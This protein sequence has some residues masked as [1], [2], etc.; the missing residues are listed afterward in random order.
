MQT[1]AT[2]FRSR[3]SAAFP[4]RSLRARLASGAS[5]S[6]FQAVATH[7]L[8][9][10]STI[11]IARLL[12][13]TGFGELAAVESSIAMFGVL[14]GLGLGLTANKHL[15][16]Y[17]V[18]DPQRA[19]RILGLAYMTA[20][21]SGLFMT[22]LVV[23]AGQWLAT[24]ALD[25]PELGKYVRW[26]AP[27][28]LLGTL[29]G[30]LGEA[31]YG[32]E[33][34]RR[35][36]ICRPAISLITA[37]GTVLGVIW[38]GVGGAVIGMVAANLAGVMI[39]QRALSYECRRAGVPIRFH[40][41]WGERNL[42]WSFSL[43]SALSGATNVTAMWAA[44]AILL[45]THGGVGQLALYN[46][47]N[48]WQ[49]ML[50]FLPA[51]LL[52][53][54]L[55]IMASTL[56][57]ESRQKFT[58]TLDV[59]H[60]IISAVV[61]PLAILLIAFAKPAM[62]LYGSGFTAGAMVLGLML[63]GT[64]IS[65]IGAPVGTA[66]NASGKIWIGFAMNLAWSVTYVV[67]AALTVHRL[68]AVGLAAGFCGA[69][70][71]Q[72]TWG[73]IYLRKELPRAMVLR[74]VASIATVFIAASLLATPTAYRMGIGILICIAVT[75][76]VVFVFTSSA[77]RRAALELVMRRAAPAPAAGGAE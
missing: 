64:A 17:R 32:L 67:I 76:L 66:L 68:G 11:C 1:I 20:I 22:L 40:G 31:L 74:T 4:A 42:L 69:H 70:A 52:V 30:L 16:E 7:G 12:G 47:S 25:L 39:L 62:G 36:A 61:V 19:G 23:V 59:T 49:L 15:A 60:S 46:A 63:A 48:S 38:G 71:L 29:S 43:P 24:H 50:R 26:G 13:K 51:Q 33:A 41:A 45:H 28:V 27:L 21:V 3:L 54:A 57:S 5:W 8:T 72:S 14:A 75:G 44:G 34:F 53:A 77:I 6:L 18:A 56:Q 73:F 37:T 65:C 10:V 58:K 55:P 2:N 9:A 35:L